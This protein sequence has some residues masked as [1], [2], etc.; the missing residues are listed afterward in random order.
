MLLVIT[1][2][3]WEK[4][5]DHFIMSMVVVLFMSSKFGIMFQVSLSICKFKFGW[6]GSPYFLNLVDYIMIIQHEMILN[7]ILQPHTLYDS[8]GLSYIMFLL[9]W[10]VAWWS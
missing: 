4:M 10:K 6:Y 8:V 9:Y 3:V 7:Y 2:K 1:T 5:H